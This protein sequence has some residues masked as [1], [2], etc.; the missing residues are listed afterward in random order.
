MDKEK[1]VVDI[2]KIIELCE[3]AIEENPDNATAHHDLGVAL[4]Q[5][6]NVDGALE[7]LSKA[8]ELA[9]RSVLTHYLL[10][11]AKAEK[12]E[13]D[14]AID[15]WKKVLSLDKP[16]KHKLNGM[17]HYFIGKVYGLK[18]M[19]DASHMELR[20]AKK[21]LPNHPLI[22]NTMAE[23][24]L[25]KGELQKAKQ[26]WLDVAAI[27]TDDARAAFNVCAIAVDTADYPLALEYGQKV[28]A[29][30]EDGG[31]VRFNIG[32]AHLR[33]GDYDAAIAN[34][35]KALEFEPDDL[36]NL[37][38]LGEAYVEKGLI[39]EGAKRWEAAAAQ[40]PQAAEPYYN[41]GL[42]Y[43]RNDLL[44]QAEEYWQKALE[45]EPRYLPVFI[46]QG[47]FYGKQGQWQESLDAWQKALEIDP[48]AD[49]VRINAMSTYV[50]MGEYE[51]ALALANAEQL[52]QPDF[53]FVEALCHLQLGQEQAWP[54][55]DSLYKENPQVFSEQANLINVA[56]NKA[57]LAAAPTRYAEVAE[58]ML[59]LKS[60]RDLP[61]AQQGGRSIDDP[62][63]KG[64]LASFLDSL[65]K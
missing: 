59:E 11:V 18:G 41:I 61:L 25:V 40:Y 58:A 60:G 34:L 8:A 13:L 42:A 37:L 4:F 28:L 57:L 31:G 23:I 27:A 35:E 26:E 47:T 45:R 17:T 51:A 21:L 9:P 24:Y 32:L 22:M 15:S 20:R 50:C 55:L 1:P 29:M 52:K 53:A 63:N 65:R 19:W 49:M 16:N 33:S 30:G 7:H 62:K 64:W 39:D 43:A 3:K 44:K 14:E 46:A 38:T 12:S 10:G 48:S 56:I 6:Q 5:K 36:N 54:K 2:E